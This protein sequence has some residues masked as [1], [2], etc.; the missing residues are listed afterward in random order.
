MRSVCYGLVAAGWSC[1]PVVCRTAAAATLLTALTCVLPAPAQTP[2]PLTLPAAQALAAQRATAVLVAQRDASVATLDVARLRADLRPQVRLNATV[3]SYFRSFRETVQPDGSIRFQP[4]TVNN[5]SVGVS[6]AQAFAKTGGTLALSTGLQRFDDFEQDF[7]LYNGSIARLGYTQPLWGFNRLKWDR[8][9]IPLVARETDAR[10]VA[11]KLEAELAAT[12]AF[13]DLA[14]AQL[15]FQIAD[16]NAMAAERLLAI[17]NE[18]YALGKVSRGDQVQIELELADAQQNR[19]RARQVWLGATADFRALMGEDFGG[20]PLAVVPPVVAEADI[21]GDKTAD[22]DIE[23]DIATALAQ[24]RAR[25]PEALTRARRILEAE[26]Q[27]ERDN[28]DNGFRADLSASVGLIRSDP[29]L[30][31]VYA[32]PQLEQVAEVRL[33]VPIIDWGRRRA[34]VGQSEAEVVLAKALGRRAE[35][36]LETQV[37]LAVQQVD[38]SRAELQLLSRV[39]DLAEERYRI[40]RESYVLGAVPLTELTLAQ[41]ARDQRLR[42]YLGGLENVFTAQAQLRALTAAP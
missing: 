37:R 17:A 26:A 10:L 18:R 5:S 35:Q 28:R 22:A 6:A 29:K 27:L 42:Q 4:V 41:Q 20:E 39:R 16:A 14:A 30:A 2:A 13:F 34:L 12:R 19:L 25:R 8:Q 21:A 9:I 32:D 7:N 23:T 3:P 11:A 33:S 15:A 1:K 31:E 36:T 38:Q 40:A 24:A